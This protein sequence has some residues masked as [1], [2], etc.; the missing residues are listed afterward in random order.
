MYDSRPHCE[1]ANYSTTHRHAVQNSLDWLS[2]LV[3]RKEEF[4]R[5][6]WAVLEEKETII[7]GDYVVAK[8]DEYCDYNLE[9]I[10]CLHCR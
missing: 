9:K 2:L 4:N 10:V 8:N 6:G 1:A 3:A 7:V 5:S